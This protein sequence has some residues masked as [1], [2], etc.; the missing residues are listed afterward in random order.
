MRSV[1]DPSAPGPACRSCSRCTR[2]RAPPCRRGG[3]S[4]LRGRPREIRRRQSPP[5]KRRRTPPRCTSPAVRTRRAKCLV[6][7]VKERWEARSGRARRKEV[8]GIGWSVGSRRWCRWCNYLTLFLHFLDVLA[9]AQQ[10]LGEPPPHP[11]PH[12]P[13]ET[14]RQRERVEH[15]S[16]LCQF[17]FFRSFL[18][19]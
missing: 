7:R 19:A 3:R 6:S 2:S 5:P 14:E 15:T 8:D 1:L 17:C 9:A 12:P 18:R 13:S 16:A 11:L 4:R 10:L